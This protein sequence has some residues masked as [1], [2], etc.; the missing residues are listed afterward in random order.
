MPHAKIATRQAKFTLE[1][2]HAELGGKILDNAAEAKRLRASMV[3]VEAVLK[4]LVPGYDVRSIA[5]RRRKPNAWF[6][7]GTV[8]RAALNVLRSAESPLTTRE[9]TDQML[10]AKGVT[11]ASDKAFRDLAGAVQSSL[12]NHRGKTVIADDRG[13]P[14]RW[15][16]RTLVLSGRPQP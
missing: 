13:M 6:K 16:V 3:H 15:A 2:L 11:N 14:V 4:M 9:I 1:Q 8:F 10:A 7:R 5:I 12:R